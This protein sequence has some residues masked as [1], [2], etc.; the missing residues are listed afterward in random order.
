VDDRVIMNE[1]GKVNQFHDGCEGDRI[2]RWT[3]SDPVAEEEKRGPEELTSHEEEIFVDLL[4]QVEIRHDDSLQLT[5][6]FLQPIGD[7]DLYRRQIRRRATQN[8]TV[9]RFHY[10]IYR[11]S[12][13]HRSDLAGS[14]YGGHE[15]DR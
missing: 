12:Q 14:N 5:L 8:R 15:G 2:L 4:D 1:C 11:I 9:N 13:L 7:E 10:L 6:D 3:V